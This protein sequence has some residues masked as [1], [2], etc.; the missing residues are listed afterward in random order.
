[1]ESKKLSELAASFTELISYME[2]LVNTLERASES[3][4]SGDELRA[5]G[6]TA[7][8]EAHIVKLK[9]GIARAE[10]LLKSTMGK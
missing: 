6:F 8:A 5:R 4:E 3:A 10:A 7:I 1:M 2:G 9:G